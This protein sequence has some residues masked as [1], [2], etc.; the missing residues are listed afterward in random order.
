MR[1]LSATSIFVLIPLFL[2]VL[3]VPV[4]SFPYFPVDSVYRPLA[5][6]PL[7]AVIFYAIFSG[8]F[9][10]LGVLVAVFSLSLGL[11]S[12]LTTLIYDFPTEHL[13]KSLSTTVLLAIM[14]SAF[15]VI[16]NP[17]IISPEQRRFA[18]GTASFLALVCTFMF[19]LIQFLSSSMGILQGVSNEVTSLFSYRSVGRVQGL[20]GEPSQLIRNTMLIGIFSILLN[21]HILRAISIGMCFFIVL[22]SG[23]TYGYLLIAI[24][25]AVY[26]FLFELKAIA[27]IKVL[28]VVAAFSIFLSYFY[29]N[30]M[31]SYSKNKIDKV[32]EVVE[33]PQSLVTVVET[34]GSIFQRVMNPYIGFTSFGLENI[35]GRGLD[36]YRYEYPD[37][38]L[39]KYVYAIEFD[40]VENA[41]VGNNY[42]TPKSLYSKVYFELGW[43][44]FGSMIFSYL[45]FYFKVLRTKYESDK[46]LL[47]FSFC[48]AVVY[49]INTDSII[50][51]NY[52][53]LVMILVSS[54]YY[55]SRLF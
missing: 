12:I 24:L 7:T 31:G 18:L 10:L 41:V 1:Y 19:V 48:L 9:N 43:F 52:W 51:F 40:T 16:F 44:V 5:I 35:F 32:V 2:S 33:N 3:L 29:S 6:L 36:T 23:S 49:P 27:N 20:S 21:R 22:V 39:L 53:V 8:R 37:Q 17:R 42:I 25:I 15:S 55:R 4:D 30:H 11:H 47:R 54:I 13:P 26:I 50:F 45:F 38:I 46:H 28:A 14:L 34:D